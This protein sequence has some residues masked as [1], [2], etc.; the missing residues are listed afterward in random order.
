MTAAAVDDLK[1]QEAKLADRDLT[2]VKVVVEQT[3]EREHLAK[4][5]EEV[6]EAQASHA[7]HVS[8]VMAQLDTR[9]KKILAS[10]EA[11]AAS[12]R[13]VFSYLELR[14]RQALKSICR[15]G[16]KGLLATLE[17]GYVGFSSRLT[18]ELE[19]AGAKVDGILE[20]EFHDLFSMA[21][22]CLFSHL[23]LRNTS[24]AFDA[25]IGPIPREFPV[26]MA[27]AMEGHVAALLGKFTCVDDGSAA[28]EAGG[29]GNDDVEDGPIAAEAAG[30][31]D[32]DGPSS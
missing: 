13:D 8:E 10:V 27:E 25:V 20:E 21:T 23:Y 2:L 29:G 14:A 4:L 31:D 6:T 9:E 30:S 15:R 19:G 18:T 5:Q 16:F 28:A 1:A 12:D 22:P 24:F 7:R 17:D 32:D 11:K 3:A 26:V